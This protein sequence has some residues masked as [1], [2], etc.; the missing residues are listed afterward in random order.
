MD[1]QES[2][3]DTGLPPPSLGKSAQNQSQLTFEM[4]LASIPIPS[5]GSI[6]EIGL[7]AISAALI[8]RVVYNLYFHPLS[9]YH[10]PWYAASFSL[11]HALISVMK[12]E[13]EWMLW[14]SKQ[15]GTDKPIRVAPT[16]LLFPQSA[17]LKDIYWDPKCNNKSMFYGT[18]SLG[19]PHLFSTL[20][21]NVHKS[22]RKAL[23]G[24]QWSIGGLKNNWEPRFDAHIQ[25]FISR[26]SDFARNNEPVILSDKVAE[27]A[28]DI[29]TM[30]S[31][32]DPWGFVTN[33]RDERN[34][35]AS[36]RRG[37]FSFGFVNRFRWL[38]DRVTRV[39]WGHFFLPSTSDDVGMGYL[40]AQADRQVS[41]RERRMEEEAFTQEKPDFMQLALEARIDGKPLTSSQKRAHVTLL[42]QAGADTTGTALGSTLRFLLTHPLALARARAEISAAEQA[43][44]LS[45]TIQYEETRTHLPFFVAC[46]KEAI[47][48]HPSATNLFARVAPAG[49]KVVDGTWVPAGAE[50]TANA[51][52]VQR[53]PRLY[54]PDPEAFRPERW[55][56]G[57]V[58]GNTKEAI[59]EMEACIFAFG[60]GPRVCLGKDVAYMEM[61]KLLPETVRRF[62]FDMK[63]EG[64]IVVVGGIAYNEDFVVQLRVRE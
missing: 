30:V 41:E 34:M 38:R 20:D 43:G 9:K 3:T 1:D 61:Y 49:G 44:Q 18:G 13:P 16:L 27:F 25:L 42:I 35:L 17:A 57:E 5:P 54:G 60:I 10:G 6:L 63:R 28:A 7:L 53:D 47:R 19:P 56:E 2:T 36:W 33:S 8:L 55:L 24:P 29:M 37:L 51:W 39:W 40:M 4:A 45:P 46:I 21:G 64:R 52:V 59:S 62:D 31:F 26:M 22:L 23:G 15:Y 48:L 14:L 32:T 50:I 12:Y 11:V 58:G